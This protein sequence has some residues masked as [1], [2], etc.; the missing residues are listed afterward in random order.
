MK[1]FIIIIILLGGV[2][3]GGYRFYFQ[4]EETSETRENYNYAKIERKNI[5][6]MITA[7]GSLEAGSS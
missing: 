4:E 1:K 2:G 7:T 6:N 5:L 3:Y